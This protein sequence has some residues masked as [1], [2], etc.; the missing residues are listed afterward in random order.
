M[1]RVGIVGITGFMGAELARLIIPHPN[2]ELTMACAGS[3]A[4]QKLADNRPGFGALDDLIVAESDPA[5]LAENCDLVFLAL[6]HGKSADIAEELLLKAVKVIDLG[7]DFRVKDRVVSEALYQRPAPSQSLLNQ[8]E[9]CLPEITGRPSKDVQLIA[10]PGCFATALTF[11]LSGWP[12]EQAT[13]F[14]VTGSSGSGIEPSPGV[15]HSLRTTNFTAYKPLQHQHIGE[16]SQTLKSLGKDIEIDFVPHSAPMVRGIH[17]TAVCKRP[18]E[19]LETRYAFLRNQTLVTIQRGAIPMGAVVGTCRVLIGL[20]PSP[21]NTKT[22][23][24]VAIDNLLKGGSGQAVQIA[25]LLFD[26]PETTGLPLIG[27]WP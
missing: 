26:L 7:S 13:I 22:T 17:L 8:A 18:V 10:A 25:N 2:F 23:I 21:D 4:G 14:G 20:S 3:S 9:Y 5:K 1:I 12:D 19:D 24:C 15:H 16:V 6:P 27:Q 11:L